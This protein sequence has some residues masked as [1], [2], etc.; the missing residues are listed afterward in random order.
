MSN[1]TSHLTGMRMSSYVEIANLFTQRSTV[2]A[3]TYEVVF[4]QLI[5]YVISTKR[6][7]RNHAV[8]RMALGHVL[9]DKVQ[10]NI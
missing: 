4:R 3:H 8:I 1:I 7:T 5:L 6:T 10:L 2:P 9:P